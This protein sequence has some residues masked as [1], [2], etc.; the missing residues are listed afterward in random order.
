MCL[1]QAW[2]FARSPERIPDVAFCRLAWSRL[3]L[4]GSTR[5]FRQFQSLPL[6]SQQIILCSNFVVE[7]SQFIM[8]RHLDDTI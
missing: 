2:Y 3:H 7:L 1:S 8:Y 6:N 5:P 4:A